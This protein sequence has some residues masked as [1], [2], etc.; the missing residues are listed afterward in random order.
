MI[1]I[2]GAPGSGKSFLGNLIYEKER[3]L[4]NTRV[5]HFSIADIS[6]EQQRERERTRRS[7][8]DHDFYDR[9]DRYKIND[10]AL[11]R[12]FQDDLRK[13][14][15]TFYIVELE[16]GNRSTM[17]SFE[18]L[19]IS[20][21]KTKPYM[22]EIHQPQEVCMRFCR[23]FRS[24]MEISK[25]CE[26]IEK[27]EPSEKVLLIDPTE[28]YKRDYNC[29]K[30]ISIMKKSMKARNYSTGAHRMDYEPNPIKNPLNGMTFTDEPKDMAGQIYEVL[31]DPEI[32]QM[33]LPLISKMSLDEK[34]HQDKLKLLEG[35]IFTPK[36]VFDYNHQHKATWDEIFTTCQPSVIINYNHQ[37]SEKLSEVVKDIDIDAEIEMR[38]TL[39]RKEKILWYLE[40]AEKPEDTASNCDYPNNWEIAT[41]MDELKV[42]RK[43][44]KNK[45]EKLTGKLEKRK[46]NQIEDISNSVPEKMDFEN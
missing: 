42:T 22:I 20:F 5:S 19:A 7:R 39:Q 25:I 44:K 23:N 2:R 24:R 46:R 32:L 16:G 30:M 9:H 41:H 45:T 21:G 10:D 3:S 17:Q 12:K 35:K 43:R 34:A 36:K 37:T 6:Q 14:Q 4:G 13:K 1:L 18:D 15:T 26:D 27:F 31:Q 29:E 33:V 38:K 40:N 28:L 11:Y 8:Y